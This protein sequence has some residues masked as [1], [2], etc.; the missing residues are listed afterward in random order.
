MSN[1][2]IRKPEEITAAFNAGTRDL[3]QRLEKKSRSEDEIAN[4]DRLKKRISLV[5]N[6]LGESFLLQNAAPVF[7]EFSDY[8][9]E[10]DEQK[11]DSFFLE[12]NVR[13]ECMKRGAHL[14]KSDEFIFS[15]IDSIRAYY[16]RASSAE[17]KD[18]Y[19]EIRKLL[20]CC[21]EY[22]LLFP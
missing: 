8:I 14:D 15:L 10:K 9:L 11:R 7:V 21:V 12:Y 4:L 17:K 16:K 20:E 5:K 19:A 6:S 1:L 3:I 22:K 13:A 18:I 2:K